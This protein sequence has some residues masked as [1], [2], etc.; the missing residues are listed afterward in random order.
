MKLGD[1]RLVGSRGG[2][3]GS[4]CVGYFRFYFTVLFWFSFLVQPRMPIK[5][6]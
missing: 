2:A 5:S 6:G 4:G 1:Y 3:N